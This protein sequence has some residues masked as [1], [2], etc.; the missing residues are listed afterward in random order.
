ML[1]NRCWEIEK[2]ENNALAVVFI[3]RKRSISATSYD[4]LTCICN[5]KLNEP[6]RLES[7]TIDVSSDVHRAEFAID[8]G[9]VSGS[10][11]LS[12]KVELQMFWIMKAPTTAPAIDNS[13]VMTSFLTDMQ[14]LASIENLSDVVVSCG[15]EEIAVHKL[16][17]AARSSVFKAMFSSE[18]IESISGKVAIT[19]FELPVVKAF[20]EFIYTGKFTA[21]HVTQLMAM[22]DQYQ[23]EILKE[24]CELHLLRNVTKT[25]ALE[26]F[27]L[28][29]IH[30]SQFGLK[31]KAVQVIKEE[32][33]LPW[34]VP[35]SVIN[36]F[37]KFMDVVESKMYID[38]LVDA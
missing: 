19:N 33:L 7:F 5:Y 15:G 6:E 21:Q 25:N 16:V 27:C 11:E 13:K 22:A 28:A 9:E 23:V 31:Q 4:G 8:A 35:T 38:R 3:I 34:Y 17:L 20:L 2:R 29:H 10:F 37:Q 1:L 18:M 12:A 14:Q 32:I 26:V 36:D 30:N 24:L